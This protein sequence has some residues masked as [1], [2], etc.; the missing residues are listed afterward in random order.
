MDFVPFTLNSKRK[1]VMSVQMKI[2]H[3]IHIRY[4]MHTSITICGYQVQGNIHYHHFRNCFFEHYSLKLYMQTPF[5]LPQFIYP[6]IQQSTLYSTHIHTMYTLALGYVFQQPSLLYWIV[7]DYPWY[8]DLTHSP[9]Y[10]NSIATVFW[11]CLLF[12]TPLLL[13]L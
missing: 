10:P 1:G 9:E 6:Y 11:F 3:G 13:Q 5:Y 7:D 4:F 8:R 12:T 2:F